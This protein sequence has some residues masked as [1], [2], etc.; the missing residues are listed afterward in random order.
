[1]KSYG[2]HYTFRSLLYIKKNNRISKFSV[3]VSFDNEMSDFRNS[4]KGGAIKHSIIQSHQRKI[5]ILWAVCIE[6]KHWILLAKAGVGF[7]AEPEGWL[8]GGFVSGG[9]PRE[10]HNNADQHSMRLC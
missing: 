3:P 10:G 6:T 5:A 9:G 4:N 7:G 1:M 2:K 8:M